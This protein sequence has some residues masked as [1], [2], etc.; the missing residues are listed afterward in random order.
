MNAPDSS[1]GKGAFKGLEVEASG[2]E[3]PD[4]GLRIKTEVQAAAASLS[5]IG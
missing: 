2:V 3:C 1:E 4:S 5:L